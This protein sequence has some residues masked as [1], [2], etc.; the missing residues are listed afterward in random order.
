ME[1]K[2]DIPHKE[3]IAISKDDLSDTLKEYKKFMLSRGDMIMMAVAFILGASFEGVVKSFSGNILMPIINYL[4]SNAGH[5]EDWT[6]SVAEGL[7]L[8]VGKALAS[9]VEFVLISI[10]LFFVIKFTGRL[11]KV[12]S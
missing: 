5:W 12:T 9:C 10:V 2:N 11:K 1:T 8:N 3:I 4:M 6:F 7:K